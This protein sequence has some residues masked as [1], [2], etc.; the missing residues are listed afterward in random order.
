MDIIAFCQNVRAVWYN[1]Y[2]NE[3]NHLEKKI[4]FSLDTYLATF[5]TFWTT[6]KFSNGGFLVCL[7]TRPPF[8][9]AN[10]FP[11]IDKWASLWKMNSNQ[12]DIYTV[13]KASVVSSIWSSYSI[14][15]V[16]VCIMIMYNKIIL[17]IIHLHQ[18]LTMYDKPTSVSQVLCIILQAFLC[19][20]F[21]QKEMKNREK[22]YFSN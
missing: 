9:F 8:C 22:V 7:A 16:Y 6:C 3:N 12:E 20:T 21:H 2:L 10:L 13:Y 18:S 17:K 15:F 1:F 19:F 11:G 5:F 14:I 4:S